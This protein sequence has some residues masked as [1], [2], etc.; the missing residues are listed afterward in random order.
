[1]RLLN[2]HMPQGREAFLMTECNRQPLLFSNL[3]SQSVVA[4][5]DGGRLTSDAG[6]L[7]L[8]EA[9]RRLGLI[10]RLAACLT[11]PR[12]PARIIHDQET[13]LAQ[14]IHGIALG[15]E[16]LN[17]HDTLRDDPLFSV[18][19][20]KR[21]DPDEPL[22]SSPTLCR[23]E[24]RVDRIS[25][26]RMAEVFVETFIAS[27]RCPPK[28][29]ILDF[30]ATDDRVH[31]LQEHRFFHGYYDDYCFLP[32]YVFC[33]DQLL[34]AYL[35]PSN[36]DPS[37]HTRAI[38]KLLVERFRQ[39]WPDVKIVIRADSGFCRWRTMKWCE[40]HGVF[41]VF[42]LVRNKVLERMA[43]PFM[44]RAERA[45]EHTGR[46]QRRFHEIR[47]AAK[48][49]DR[50]R[51]VIVKAERLSQ[52]PNTRFV[53][54][55]IRERRPAQIYDGLY[56]P[57]GDMENRIKEQQLHLFA[58]RTSCHRFVPN[59]F[60]LMLASAAYVLVDHLR[61]TVLKGTEL[62][63]AQVATIRLKLFKVAARVRTS[64]RR[65]VFHFSSSYPYQ[66]LFRH[67]VARLVP[68]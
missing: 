65:V 6:G 31:G 19:A 44:D 15:Y 36:I 23:F 24:N 43:E 58:D 41:Y 2:R 28:E 30:D 57:R 10:R 5:F 40:N 26:W 27:H 1:M 67:I 38:L 60:R 3:K 9:D 68:E 63:C 32:L 17:D 34:V 39:V 47:Y 29:L 22:A 25:L 61:R 62:A 52:G 33:G 16:D 18:L 46:K 8:R 7:L 54:T 42:G 45:F 11:D 37:K 14:R 50:K 13:L 35:R 64:V 49:W 21:P 56:T 51:R 48:T 55:N 53:V 12:D 4:D 66:P 20:D 59:Q